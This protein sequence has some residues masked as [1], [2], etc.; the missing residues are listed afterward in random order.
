MDFAVVIVE[1]SSTLPYNK[2]REFFENLYLG[3]LRRRT[4]SSYSTTRCVLFRRDQIR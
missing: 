4:T 1:F 3:G 2:M